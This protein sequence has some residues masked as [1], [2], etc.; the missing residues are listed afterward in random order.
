L[1]TEYEIVSGLNSGDNVVVEG[2]ARLTNGATVEV[3]Q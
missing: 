2:H 1:D 3:I